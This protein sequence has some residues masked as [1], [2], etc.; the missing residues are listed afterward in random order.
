[1]ADE[2]MHTAGSAR[3]LDLNQMH[4]GGIIYQFSEAPVVLTK[5]NNRRVRSPIVCRL[6]DQNSHRAAI[7]PGY[8]VALGDP[9]TRKNALKFMAS[10]PSINGRSN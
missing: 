1:M 10:K 3:S 9:I 5:I 6:R 8:D 4:A 2:I 7:M